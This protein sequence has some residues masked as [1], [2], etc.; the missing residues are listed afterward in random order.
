MKLSL[1][2]VGLPN[3]GLA[4]NSAAKHFVSLRE[5]LFCTGREVVI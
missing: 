4:Q 5:V 3:V 1:G 2:I